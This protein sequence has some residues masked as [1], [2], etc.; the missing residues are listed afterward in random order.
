MRVVLLS[1]GL[2]SS[3]A[4]AVARESGTVDLGLFLDYGQR[5]SV[6][7]EA[8]ARAVARRFGVPFRTEPLPLLARMGGALTHR[9]PV[10]LLRPEELGDAQ[11][12]QE[13]AAAVWV[14]NRNGL[15]INMAAAIADDNGGGEIIVGF[16]LE[17]AATFPDNS[18]A[19]VKAADEFLAFS[20]R[21]KVRVL[22]PLAE[23][24]KEE[25]VR[26]GLGLGVPMESIWSCYEGAAAMCGECESCQRLKRAYA[27]VG[28][29]ELWTGR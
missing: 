23:L 5:A 4:L 10:P 12:L 21:E 29:S 3:V 8:S 18:R 17:E 13:T 9:G 1:G 24:N 15:F 22:A 19:F 26:R 14:P 20:C 2:D 7:E 25:I 27:A 28:R 16:N 6:R 11:R